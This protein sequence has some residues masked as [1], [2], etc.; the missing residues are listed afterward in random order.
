MVNSIAITAGHSSKVVG[1]SSDYGVENTL[2]TVFITK[3]RLKL[4]ELGFEKVKTFSSNA[5][6]VTKYL[7]A[8]VEFSDNTGYELALQVHFNAG[9]GTG[10]ECLYYPGNAT[11]QAMA[12]ALSKAVAGAMGIT[13]RG[14][15]A[16][17]DLYFLKNT[18]VNALL[19][20]VC[21]IDSASDM[22][23]YNV[24][25][26]AIILAIIKT[27]TG[28]QPETL[29]SGTAKGFTATDKAELLNII[30]DLLEKVNALET[31]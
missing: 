19:L 27:L 21:F 25:I 17:D 24:H 4:Q 16:R 13:N 20:E 22:I 8:Q 28:L 29:R 15:K 7:Q 31:I 3:L 2:A 26:D 5:D 12:G 23:S 1:A 9:G 18:K 30:N 11:T 10:T 14:A 6:S